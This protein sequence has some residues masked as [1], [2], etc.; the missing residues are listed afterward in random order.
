MKQVSSVYANSMKSTLRNRS[1]VK[2]V[3]GD[4]NTKATKV[5]KFSS[6]G[7][8][9]YSD[10]DTLKYDYPYDL[11]CATLELNR[12][13]LNGKSKILSNKST[14]RDGF[15]SNVLS[16]ENGVFVTSP[17]LTISFPQKY[18]FPG[19]SLKFDTRMNEWPNE[20]YINWY[21]DDTLIDSKTIIPTTSQIALSYG[22]S[23]CNKITVS[24]S[25]ILPYRRFRIEEVILGIERNYLNSEIISLQEKSDVDPI[26]RRLPKEDFKFTIVDY[27]HLYDPDNPDG[28]Y[29][30]ID[31]K[32]PVR[33]SF[34]YELPNGQVEW[35]MPDHYLLSGKP[36]TKNSKTSFSGTRQIEALSEIYYKSTLGEK[37]LYTLAENVLVDAGLIADDGTNLWIIDDSLKSIK[38]TAALPICTH[39]ECL[40]LIAHAG[41]CKLYTDN[42]GIIHIEPFSIQNQDSTFSLDFNSIYENTQIGTK[43]A[44]LRSIII[45]KYSYTENGT[46][47]LFEG[48]TS[49]TICHVE[50]D[51]FAKDIQISV[52]GGSLISSKVFAKA[53]DLVLSEGSKKIIITG[54]TLSQVTSKITY[55]VNSNGEDDQIENPL[56]TTDSMAISLA[57]HIKS[58]LIYRSTYDLTY[59]GNPE[60]EVGDFIS[61]ETPYTNKM[62]SLVLTHTITFS[63]T[64]RGIMTVKGLL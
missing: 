36:T 57:N 48:E 19:L 23:N 7:E 1:Y 42:S 62:N 2:V 47:T 43:N 21:S 17:I 41:M 37:S 52:T 53:A 31:S 60:V 20:I 46:Q 58:Y 34:G 40:Q 15:I 63:G 59:R 24:A 55:K 61:V 33:I 50:F 27:Q 39:A 16:D 11:T 35:L 4:V 29:K 38:T 45:S 9:P 51:S 8:L 6:N 14:D 49:E 10:T 26:S 56:I 54:T 64:L 32:A 13:R 18:I 22:V 44:E 12:W 5:E 3:F 30:F 25:K 28:I